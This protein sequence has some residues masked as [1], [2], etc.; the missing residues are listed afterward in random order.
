M[1]D[2]IIEQRG[3]WFEE[4][5]PDALYVHR[6]GRTLTEADTTFF[7][8]L[9]M[10]QQALHVDAAFAAAQEFGRPLANSMQVLAIMVGLSSGHLTQGTLVANLGLSEVTFPAPMFAGDTLSVTTRC[11]STRLSRS[12]PGQ[13][14]VTFEHTGR[15][16]DDV[17]VARA[18]RT[19]LVHCR[20]DE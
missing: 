13:G 3:L 2:R 12:R 17:V 15:N 10:N 16:Q 6:P 1:A 8:A 7:S 19:V 20:L 18:E 14:I 11:L 5:E 4:F 9:T